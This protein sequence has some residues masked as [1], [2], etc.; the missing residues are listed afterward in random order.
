MVGGGIFINAIG[1]G[2]GIFAID[3]ILKASG[4][5]VIRYRRRARAL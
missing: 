4:E 2:Y 5:Y 1:T 3:I